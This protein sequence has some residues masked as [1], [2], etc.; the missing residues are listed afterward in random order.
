MKKLDNFQ[1]LVA[2]LLIMLY[3]FNIPHVQLE[4]NQPGFNLRTSLVHA[5]NIE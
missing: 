4:L 5:N 3:D 2:I 1:L